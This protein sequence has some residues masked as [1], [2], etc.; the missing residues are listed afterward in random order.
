MTISPYH[1]IENMG[2]LYTSSEDI[3]ALAT[4]RLVWTGL[5]APTTG[6]KEIRFCL[7]LLSR[8]RLSHDR[9]MTNQCQCYTIS[10]VLESIQSPRTLLSNLTSTSL[11]PL[12]V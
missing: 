4:Q 2:Q 8:G 6:G 10:K 1:I 9:L 11:A 7:P 3:Y 5:G 12:S